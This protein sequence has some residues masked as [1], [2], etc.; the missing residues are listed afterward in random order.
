MLY[1]VINV[2]EFGLGV[3]ALVTALEDVMLLVMAKYGVHGYAGSP[4]G[5][6]GMN[7]GYGLK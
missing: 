1:P 6:V 7:T 4:M 2:K 5:Q 3:K